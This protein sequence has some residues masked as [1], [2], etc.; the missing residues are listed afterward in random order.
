MP[1]AI[2]VRLSAL[3]CAA[4]LVIDGDQQFTAGRGAIISL[5]SLAAMSIMLATIGSC[6]GPESGNRSGAT[7]DMRPSRTAS[8]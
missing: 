8:T 3:R 5:R 7:S 6:Q 2:L 1:V 4:S